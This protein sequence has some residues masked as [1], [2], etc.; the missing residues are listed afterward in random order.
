MVR[1]LS[2]TFLLVVFAAT[3][4]AAAAQAQGVPPDTSNPAPSKETAPADSDRL[5]SRGI[6]GFGMVQQCGARRPG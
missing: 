2:T 3:T 6:G 4:L 1:Q 5:D